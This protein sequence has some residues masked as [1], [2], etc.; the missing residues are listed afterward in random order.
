MAQ[1]LFPS[2][3]SGDR[4]NSSPQRTQRA[5]EKYLKHQPVFASVFSVSSV[6]IASVS[7]VVI[8]F[9]GSAQLYSCRKPSPEGS[10]SG[11]G[12]LSVTTANYR[13]ASG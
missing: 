7:S 1:T 8:A 12:L 5:T 4:G 13:E 11:R 2:K 3:S 10:F 6:V 9:S